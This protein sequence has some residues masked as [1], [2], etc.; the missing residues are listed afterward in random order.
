MCEFDTHIACAVENLE[1]QSIQHPSFPQS[2]ALLKQL[3]STQTDD[4]IRLNGSVG[5]RSI[6]YDI[7]RLVAQNIGGGNNNR[8]TGLKKDQLFDDGAVIGWDKR[9]YSSRKKHNTS[10]DGKRKIVELQEIESY[11]EERTPLREKLTPLSDKSVPFSNQFSD[12]YFSIDLAKSYDPRSQMGKEVSSDQKNRFVMSER[13]NESNSGQVEDP[14]GLVNWPS[15]NIDSYNVTYQ[16]KLKAA[17]FFKG[18]GSNDFGDSRQKVVTKN[19]NHSLSKWSIQDQTIT[20][21]ASV[22]SSQWFLFLQPASL[23]VY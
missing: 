16:N 10:S 4:A 19:P 20:K 5:D 21:S 3:S 15:I 13:N 9:L 1:P 23:Y 6:G 12:S 11:L 2:N 22:S 8:N 18:G 7:M 14:F 17:A